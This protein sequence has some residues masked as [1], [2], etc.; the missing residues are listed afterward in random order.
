MIQKV[1]V[2]TNGVDLRGESILGDIKK[3]QVK[4]VDKVTAIKVYRLEGVNVNQTKLLARRLLSE[5][6]NQSFTI[7]SPIVNGQAKIVE[8]SYKVGVMNPE[9]ASILKAC[10]DLG[11]KLLA[12]DTSFEYAFYGNIKKEEVLNLVEKL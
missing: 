2:I 3:L 4:N 6:I 11:I 12:A 10:S 8:I 5:S 1:R 7:N 9:V